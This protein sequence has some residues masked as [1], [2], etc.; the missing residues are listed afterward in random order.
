MN[1]NF[2]YEGLINARVHLLEE[3]DINIYIV[4]EGKNY[5]SIYGKIEDPLAGLVIDEIIYFLYKK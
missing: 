3:S 5:L 4:L 2:S 1:K